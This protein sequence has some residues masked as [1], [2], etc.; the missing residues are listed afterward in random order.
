[1]A[2]AACPR[3]FSPKNSYGSPTGG[4][5][6]SSHP[7]T[8]TVRSARVAAATHWAKPSKCF[9]YG[10]FLGV[11]HAAP[12]CSVPQRRGLL[13]F[14]QS[15]SENDRF[16]TL[17][18]CPARGVPVLRKWD[19]A[20]GPILWAILKQSTDCRPVTILWRMLSI[21]D[22]LLILGLPPWRR[23]S[24]QSS[25]Y[26]LTGNRVGHLGSLTSGRRVCGGYFECGI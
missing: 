1:M 3:R 6:R 5:P 24:G 13:T 21:C 9:C 12:V 26:F 7:D 8:N 18:E 11:C 10:G 20:G 19:T 23:R 2:Y 16:R 15:A 22:S 14:V 25:D 4:Q 17:A